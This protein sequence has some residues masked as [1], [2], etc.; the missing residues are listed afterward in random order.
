[1]VGWKLH[2]EGRLLPGAVVMPRAR[3][4]AAA[5]WASAFFSS[6][7]TRWSPGFISDSL[8]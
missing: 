7:I 3:Y 1:M 8:R 4:S 5:T 2:N 6:C